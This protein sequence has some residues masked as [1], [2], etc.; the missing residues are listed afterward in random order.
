MVIDVDVVNKKGISPKALI[1]WR[2]AGCKS[3][4]VHASVF[5]IGI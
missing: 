3:Q 1:C 4:A 2:L 5:K